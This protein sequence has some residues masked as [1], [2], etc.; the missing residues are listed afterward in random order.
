METHIFDFIMGFFSF[1]YRRGS[2]GERGIEKFCGQKEW[3][4]DLNAATIVMN[5][6]KSIT[7]CM[8][9]PCKNV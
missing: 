3:V 5:N 6:K 7:A 1:Y 2:S 9:P 4:V 8:N